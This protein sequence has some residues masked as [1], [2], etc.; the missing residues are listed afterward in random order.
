VS[1]GE[2]AITAS[3]AGRYAKA[4][5][6][7]A[8][9]SGCLD[10]VEADLSALRAALA[11][12]PELAE[13]LVS[14]LYSA[15]QKTGVLFA[16]ADKAGFNELTR[17]TFGVVATNRRAAELDDIAAIFSALLD[18]DRGI[19]RADVETATAMTKKQT[20]ALA[21]SLKSAF[22]REIEVRTQVR[23][24]LMGGLIVKIG[25]RMFDSSLRTKLDGMKNAMKE[26]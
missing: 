14:P 11:T 15:E 5:F 16:L 9:S 17:N 4:A 1:T 12:S 25:S 8:K 23:P 7:L 13:L 20:E 22:G 18:A 24:E 26:A 2:D 6:E 21:A 19:V 3:P 10:A